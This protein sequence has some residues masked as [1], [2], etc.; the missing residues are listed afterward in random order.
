M[1]L[2]KGVGLALWRGDAM[3]AVLTP[4]IADVIAEARPQILSPHAG[5]D[6]L[7]K[8]LPTLVTRLRELSPASQIVLGIGC[9]GWL[10]AATRKTNRVSE[11][12]A[13][14]GLAR[15]AD[16]ALSVN[17]CGSILD[18]ESA[19][20]YDSLISSRILAGTIKEMRKRAS[21]LFLG[22]TAYDQ[23]TQHS[24]DADG[25]Y[26]DWHRAGEYPWRALVGEGALEWYGAQTYILPEDGSAPMPHALAVRIMRHRASWARAV[27]LGWIAPRVHV[28][29][30]FQAYRTPVNELVQ[31]GCLFDR[32]F[33]WCGPRLPEG[34][35]DENGATALKALCELERRGYRKPGGIKEFQANAGLAA[36]GVVG[37]KTLAALGLT[38]S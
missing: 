8:P 9:D 21:N 19:A 7:A 1:T 6:R 37:K 36:D 32:V 5:P 24:D 28:D 29:A 30:Y 25:T 14:E 38:E 31:N 23:P 20:K 18:A 11:A 26:D 4:W 16:L 3:A 2:P 17:A 34:R 33:F 27:K 22:A 10:R 15:G 13:I 35:M 12:R